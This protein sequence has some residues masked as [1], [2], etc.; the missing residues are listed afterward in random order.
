MEKWQVGPMATHRH[1]G[2]EVAVIWWCAWS[3]CQ[4]DN[5][6][7][8]TLITGSGLEKWRTRRVL[9]GYARWREHAWEAHVTPPS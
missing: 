9:F 3:G 7:F 1:S 6:H 2:S 5:K 4:L 8:Y